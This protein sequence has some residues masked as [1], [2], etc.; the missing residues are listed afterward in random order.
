MF[1][2]KISSQS[3]FIPAF[4]M[5]FLLCQRSDLGQQRW[6]NSGFSLLLFLFFSDFYGMRRNKGGES[7]LPN[8]GTMKSKQKSVL[9]NVLSSTKHDCTQLLVKSNTS[10]SVG[11]WLRARATQLPKPIQQ[12][13][14]YLIIYFAVAAADTT[15]PF[16]VGFLAHRDVTCCTS[17]AAL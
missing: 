9:T 3:E 8:K 6:R 14:F 4:L 17:A 15:Q 12:G 5:L 16:R 11:T 2:L 1:L 13:L 7:S 10:A